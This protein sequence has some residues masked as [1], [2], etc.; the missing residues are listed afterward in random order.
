MGPLSDYDLGV[1][2]ERGQDSVELR[3]RLVWELARA[4]PAERV[5]AQCCIDIS[6]RII[7]LEKAQKPGD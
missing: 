1:L 2:A 3:A 5:A 4:V 6:H 7:S